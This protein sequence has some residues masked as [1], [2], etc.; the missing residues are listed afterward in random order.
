MSHGVTLKF[1]G[2]LFRFWGLPHCF[3]KF[4]NYKYDE[5]YYF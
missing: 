4:E 2:M 5:N 3:N 1:G